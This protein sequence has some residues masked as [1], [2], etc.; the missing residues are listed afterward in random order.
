[1]ELLPNL[2]VRT[3]IASHRAETANRKVEQI[4]ARNY[5]NSFS[6]NGKGSLRSRNYNGAE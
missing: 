4:V 6:E 2:L 1:M 3:Q 5:P